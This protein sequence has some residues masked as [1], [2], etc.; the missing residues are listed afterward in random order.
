[1]AGLRTFINCLLLNALPWHW[2]NNSSPTLLQFSVRSGPLNEIEHG[3]DFNLEGVPQ[4]YCW[5]S[6][7]S[8]VMVQEKVRGLVTVM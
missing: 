2:A 1:V 3:S 7:P 5:I 8:P 6:T 4:N